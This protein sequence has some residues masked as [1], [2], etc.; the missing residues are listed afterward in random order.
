MTPA[1]LTPE[2]AAHRRRLYIMIGIVGACFL[3]AGSM[4]FGYAMTHVGWMLG[5]FVV[6]I[7]AGFA[8][9][10]WM[11]VRFYQTGKPKA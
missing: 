7:L 1:D 10:G 5:A 2:L 11:I 8:A 4:V 3:I 6:A 9:Q